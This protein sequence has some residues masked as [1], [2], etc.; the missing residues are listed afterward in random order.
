MKNTNQIIRLTEDAMESHA[1]AAKAKGMKAYMKHQFDFLGIS[2]PLRRELSK[3]IFTTLKSIDA[4][5]FWQWAKYCWQLPQREYQYLVQDTLGKRKKLLNLN[6]MPDIENLI[7][8]KSW[9]DTVDYLAADIIGS[10]LL[11][12]PEH[13]HRFAQKWIQ[14]GNMWLQRTAILFQLKYNTR[15]DSDLLFDCITKLKDSKEFFIRKAAGWALRQ[16]S[17]TDSEA[18]RDFVEKNP[19]LSGLTKREAMRLI[20]D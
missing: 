10:I 14:S 18:V 3:E 15:T 9:W 13:Q 11:K 16:Y 20:K 12:N 19:S 8:T 2:A 6:D 4:I 17:K 5:G 1:D 7:L